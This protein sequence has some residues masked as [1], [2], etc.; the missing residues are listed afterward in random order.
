M[1]RNVL[2]AAFLAVTPVVVVAGEMGHAQM[3]EQ[4]LG[5]LTLSAAFARAT[6]PNQP[7][8]GAFLT[9]ANAGPADDV[10]VA[11]STPAAGRAEIHQMAME[12]GTMKMRPLPEGV[13]IP[14]GETVELKPGGIHLMLMDL[15]GPLVEGETIEATFE[16][17][18]AGEVSVT[19][20]IASP[21]AKSME[22]G[23]G[24]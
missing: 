18:D 23:H 7:V 16:F 11:V 21:G 8:A 10:L 17:R 4:H 20:A 6:L 22:H 19:F 14:A 3:A 9:I 2:V 5:D 15:A 13:T 24:S 12:G 1:I